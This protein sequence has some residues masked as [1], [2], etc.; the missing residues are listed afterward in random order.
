MSKRITVTAVEPT[1]QNIQFLFSKKSKHPE[2]NP[3]KEN[4]TITQ[5]E[6]IHGSSNT[7]LVS[8]DPL[9]QEFYN[10]LTERERRAH[11]IAMEKLGTSYDVI[12][13]HGF[14]NWMKRRK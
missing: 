4:D 11:S 13:T 12:R 14:L 7:I 2:K 5:K 3:E 1:Q 8:S 6:I 10:S 9:V